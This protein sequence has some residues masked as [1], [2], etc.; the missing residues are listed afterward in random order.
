MPPTFLAMYTCLFFFGNA[1]LKRISCA[2]KQKKCF[3][4]DLECI[5]NYLS[6]TATNRQL[7]WWKRDKKSVIKTLQ[8]CKAKRK[9]DCIA[10]CYLSCL[11]PVVCSMYSAY[12]F[13]PF[14]SAS[15]ICLS[16][17]CLS[18]VYSPYC[19]NL[20]RNVVP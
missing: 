20:S 14:L 17:F 13:Y 12:C 10:K 5:C 4:L 8:K 11:I 16:Q 3:A 6:T 9:T 15:L 19:L 7:L 2:V 18:A 1:K